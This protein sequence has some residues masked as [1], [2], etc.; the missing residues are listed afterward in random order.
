[1]A[2]CSCHLAVSDANEI[3]FLQVNITDVNEGESFLLALHSAD[4]VLHLL[5]WDGNGDVVLSP[6]EE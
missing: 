6:G 2:Y 4:E 3:V 1:M 5:F